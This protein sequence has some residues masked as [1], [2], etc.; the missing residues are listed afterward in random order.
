MRTIFLAVKLVLSNRNYLFTMIFLAIGL[1]WLFIYI[2]VRSVPGN[3]F[4]FQLSILR[5]G[6]VVLLTILS[7]LTALSLTFNIFAL[8]HKSSLQTGAS[9]IGQGA[10]GFFSG[11]LAT[12]FGSATCAYCVS[13]IFGFLGVG[14]VFFLLDYR[15]PITL[16]AITLLLISLYFTSRKVLGICEACITHGRNYD[17]K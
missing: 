6:E 10:T 2:P 9:M 16:G 7:T 1:F 4:A 12:V 5:P 8:S 17:H 11:M 15:T 3:D 13:A 14:S